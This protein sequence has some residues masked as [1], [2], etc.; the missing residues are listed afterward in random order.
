MAYIHVMR[1]N[2]KVIAA[3]NL[4]RDF[5]LRSVSVSDVVIHQV[6]LSGLFPGTE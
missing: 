1:E 3:L 4:S 6:D 2:E 5:V